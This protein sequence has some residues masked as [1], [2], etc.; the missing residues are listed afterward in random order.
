LTVACAAGLDHEAAVRYVAV[1]EREGLTRGYSLVDE[2]G[3]LDAVAD[4]EVVT[5]ADGDGFAAMVLAA[6]R[7]D[8]PET[9][10]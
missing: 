6:C 5:G 4:D 7:G 9:A 3:V 8:P 10:L 1:D 2:A